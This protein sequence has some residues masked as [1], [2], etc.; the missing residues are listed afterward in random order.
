M[1][2]GRILGSVMLVALVWTAA[3]C[4]SPNS[5]VVADVNGQK[6]YYGELTKRHEFD[7]TVDNVITQLLIRQAAEKQGIKVLPDEIKAKLDPYKNSFGKNE[8]WVKYLHGNGLTE[9]D[10]IDQIKLSVMWEKL[11]T[12][13]VKI[14][15][16]EVKKE[17]DSNPDMWKNICGSEK[18]PALTTDQI[19]S[20]TLNDIK[21]TMRDKLAQRKASSLS[22]DFIA[23]LKDKAKIDKLY[24][25]PQQKIWAKEKAVDDKKKRE[26][27]K[28]R[29]A[30]MEKQRQQ[31]A[32]GGQAGAGAQPGA[33]AGQKPGGKPGAQQAPKTDSKKGGGSSTRRK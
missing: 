2:A 24:L 20:L 15:D 22:G 29:M 28:Q 30:D 4:V 23:D 9:E 25:S 7:L 26:E 19:K 17:F 16:E 21:D 32:Q 18:K 11:L 31:A 1:S 8:D 27:Y 14:T 6:F 3:S 5:L 10:I 12:K 33:Q 13:Q